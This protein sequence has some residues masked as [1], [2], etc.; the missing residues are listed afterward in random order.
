MNNNIYNTIVVKG[1]TTSFS[2]TSFFSSQIF[3]DTLINKCRVKETI[4]HAVL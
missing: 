3:R 2:Q 4:G 1:T